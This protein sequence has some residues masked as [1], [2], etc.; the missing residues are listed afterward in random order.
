MIDLHCHIDLYNNPLEIAARAERSGVITV[1]VTNLPSHFETDYPHFS[2][3]K[4]IKLALGLHPLMATQH[5]REFTKFTRMLPK[6][7]YIGEVGLDF[8]R[9][10]INTKQEQIESF[11]FVLASVKDSYDLISIHSRQAESIVLELLEEFNISS[12]IFHWYMGSFG[13][14]ERAIKLGHYFSINT[15][16]IVSQKGKKLI[17]RIPKHRILSESD[18][19]F[20]KV[21]SKPAEP[22]DVIYVISF[23]SELWEKNREE[24]KQILINNYNN[25]LLKQ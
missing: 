25:Y 5:K 19:P 8:S 20:V 9:A 15:A 7:S 2:R 18:G 3:Y 14:L 21:G 10:G 13:I 6:T 4:R 17:E 16:M 1:A 12:A 11:R 23:L 22:T 24:V